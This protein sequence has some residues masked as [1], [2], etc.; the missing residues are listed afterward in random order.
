M[1]RPLRAA[2]DVFS[3]PLLAAALLGFVSS[4]ALS[5]A[6]VNGALSAPRGGDIL[7]YAA[8]KAGMKGT[9]LTVFSGDA[10]ESFDV[11]ILGTIDKIGPGHNLIL[12]RL[13]S[14][15]LQK[16][17]VL[18]GMS[19][20]PIYVDGKLI[21]AVA[22]AWQFASEPVAGITPIEEML[23]IPT[24]HAS[25]AGGGAG[26]RSG[27]SGIPGDLLSLLHDPAGAA[28]HFD[29]VLTTITRP[30]RVSRALGLALPATT[31][32]L[33]RDWLDARF[34]AGSAS[35]GTGQAPHASPNASDTASARTAPSIAFAFEG[36][37]KEAATAAAGGGTAA[38]GDVA[39]ARP[40]PP[41]RLAPGDA[42][43]AQLVRGDVEF[44]AFGTVTRVDGDRVLAFGHPFLQLGSI[45]LPMTRARIATVLPSLASSFKFAAAGPEVGIFEQDRAAGIAGRI[46][47]KA[48]MVPVR[49][50]IRSDDGTSKTFAYE[51]A[52]DPLLT[53][54]LLYLTLGGVLESAQKSVGDASIE[55]LEGSVILLDQDRKA[56]LSNFFS[57]RTAVQD[58]SATVGL[59][60]EALIQNE[61][62]PVTANGVNVIVAFHDDLRSARITDAWA[63]RRQARP[64]ERIIL[65]VGLKPNREDEF[66]DA[67]PIEIPKELDPGWITI[68]VGDAPSVTRIEQ[69]GTSALNPLDLDQLLDLINALRKNQSLAVLATREEPSLLIGSEPFPN[70]PPSKASRILRGD[71]RGGIP[72]LRLRTILDASRDSDFEIEGYRRVEIEIVR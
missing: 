72:I 3:A 49:L 6:S 26:S 45:A 29:N 27:A 25:G 67:I 19:G 70:L 40:V 34:G 1:I 61:F 64:G 36:V 54:V 44:T 60:A 47:P 10:P 4:G 9:G 53:P 42:V 5:A 51:V 52:A 62:E 32:G 38:A 68:H 46:G 39:T 58:M 15:I 56:D 28:A 35:A 65:S 57:G 12:A 7:P 22:Y 30:A 66:R 41:A 33:S 23:A 31:S 63:D 71:S 17:G 18:E 48:R 14:V 8:V 2:L 55:L 13:G 11:E 59:I 43:G 16:T 37:P 50:E 21:G 24:T 69:A 20:S